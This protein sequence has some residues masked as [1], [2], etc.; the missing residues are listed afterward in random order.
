MK[1]LINQIKVLSVMAA[2][3][4]VTAVSAQNK[5]ISPNEL[6]KKAQSF[7]NKHFSNQTIS[8]VSLDRNY[9][10]SKE[11]DVLLANGTKIEFSSDGAWEEVD[12]ELQT[13]PT[14]FIPTSILQYVKR[15][16]PNT[17]ITKIE[18]D[19]SGYDVKISNG[20]GLEFNSQGVFKRIDD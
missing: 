8:F 9:L 17:Q 13:I 1:K 5:I 10:M 15:S 6:P 16:F 19:R 12:G 11:Y 20:I 14:A 7:L 2:L 3:F 18:K 4:L